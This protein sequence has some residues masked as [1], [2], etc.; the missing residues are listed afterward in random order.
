MNS[1]QAAVLTALA[2]LGAKM[3]R[4]RALIDGLNIHLVPIL[5]ILLIGLIILP[6]ALNSNSVS[7]DVVLYPL[8]N[9]TT[10]ESVPGFPRTYMIQA[11]IWNHVSRVAYS[12]Y[13]RFE[14]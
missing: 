7:F 14:R 4:M 1:N 11:H 10:V 8:L 9:G 6:R 5:N 12:Y 2:E 13:L 3:N